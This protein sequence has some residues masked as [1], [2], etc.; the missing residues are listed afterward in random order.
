[1]AWA[2]KEPVPWACS[3][4]SS[5]VSG[6]WWPWLLVA[7]SL[8]TGQWDCKKEEKTE[9]RNEKANELEKWMQWRSQSGARREQACCHLINMFMLLTASPSWFVGAVFRGKQA[10]GCGSAGTSQGAG[11]RL[12]WGGGGST[13]YP[14]GGPGAEILT[15]PSPNCRI[16]SAAGLAPHQSSRQPR[17]G[18]GLCCCVGRRLGLSQRFAV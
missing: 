4:C 6:K 11:S 7:A 18:Q 3:R 10:P 1:M 14:K 5:W 15:S 17:L 9:G 12:P 2:W 13:G 16:T 8:F